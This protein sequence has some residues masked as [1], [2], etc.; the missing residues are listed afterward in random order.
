MELI[1]EKSVAGKSCAILP[2]NDVP[3]CELKESC[4]RT[5]DLG[6]PQL[7]E[8]ELSR[9]YT[10]LESNAFGVSKGYYPLGSCTMKYNPK[11]NEETAALPGFADIHPLQ[12]THTVQGCLEALDLAEIIFCEITGMDD[13]SLQPAAGAHG[14]FTGLLLI[15]K[16]HESRGD[17]KRD[18]MIIPD[19]AHGTNPASA[20]M[21]GFKTVGITSGDDGHVDLDS[22]K[23]VVG[24]DTAGLMLTNPSTLGLFEKDI[25]EIAKIVHDAGGLLYYDGANLNPI[26]GIV[27]PGDMGFDIVHLNLHK[28]FSTPHGGGGPGSGPCGCKSFLSKFLPTPRIVYESGSREFSYDFPDSMGGLKA[29][30]GNF[31]VVI[32]ALTY[33]LTLGREIV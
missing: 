29:F 17:T 11:I 28:S 19:T 23:A 13:M 14:E 10:E 24:E 4:K 20:N 27:R 7:T 25:L 21:A 16:Y 12:P 6:L 1:F 2:A 30:Y 18:K 33:V 31:L 5:T 3:Y 8:S 32:K 26:M 15:K 9:H 22:L